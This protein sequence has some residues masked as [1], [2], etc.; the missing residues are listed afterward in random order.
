MARTTTSPTSRSAVPSVRSSARSASESWRIPSGGECCSL[1]KP[2]RTCNHADSRVAHE[3]HRVRTRVRA[4][5]HP[6][7]SRLQHGRT[8]DAR[9][10]PRELVQRQDFHAD[11]RRG[12][13][14][15]AA[16]KG[17]CAPARGPDAEAQRY[18][19]PTGHARL[20]AFLVTCTLTHSPIIGSTHL[21]HREGCITTCDEKMVQDL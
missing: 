1:N 4:Q 13:G 19:G 10:L 11:A 7:L 2:Q 17:L 8:D 5:G 15:A 20:G 21:P 6:R 12:P 9:R 16:G 14:A 18:P 3:Q